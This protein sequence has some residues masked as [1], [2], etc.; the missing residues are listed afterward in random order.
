M[1]THR[2]NSHRERRFD[3]TE[4][5]ASSLM[6]TLALHFNLLRD[7]ITFRSSRLA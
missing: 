7:P 4:A 3:P 2:M 1:K 5:A 6:K